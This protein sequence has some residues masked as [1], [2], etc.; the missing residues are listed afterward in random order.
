MPLLLFWVCPQK[1]FRTRASMNAFRKAVLRM[2]LNAWRVQRPTTRSPICAFGLATLD[3]R[4]IWRTR[5]QMMRRM[6]QSMECK[7]MELMAM[8]SKKNP[9]MK[10]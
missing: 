7:K 2:Q 4:K 3:V 1:W 6:L 9:K 8:L 10:E 5:K